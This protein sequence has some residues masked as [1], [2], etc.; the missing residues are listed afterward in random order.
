MHHDRCAAALDV[1]ARCAVFKVLVDVFLSERRAVHDDVY[2]LRG[3][4]VNKSCDA[5]VDDADGCQTPWPPAAHSFTPHY[6]PVAVR[7]YA[8]G[9]AGAETDAQVIVA[10]A[11]Q[12][13]S[14]TTESATARPR[15][16][17]AS[18]EAASYRT[19]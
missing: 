1:R 13:S 8:R 9:R 3:R 7:D 19:R 4:E 16:A 14:V 5:Y 17:L 6:T 10:V 18:V 15:W 12:S 2:F 11:S